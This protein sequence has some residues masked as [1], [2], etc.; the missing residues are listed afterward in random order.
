[1]AELIV[2]S[3]PVCV[4]C[5]WFLCASVCTRSS[6]SSPAVTRPQRTPTAAKTL[7]SASAAARCL[8]TMKQAASA[9]TARTTIAMASRTGELWAY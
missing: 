9:M 4:V 3:F 8:A 1:M 6:L 2:V 5:P 7:A